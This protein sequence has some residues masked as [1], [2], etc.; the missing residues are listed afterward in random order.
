MNP[1]WPKRI[2]CGQ[3]WVTFQNAHKTGF[4]DSEIRT[5]F[6]PGTESGENVP[7][8]PVRPRFHK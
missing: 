1:G 2:V 7:G 6:W 3:G 5:R 8:G 4:S